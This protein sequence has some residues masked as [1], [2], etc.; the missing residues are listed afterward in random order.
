MLDKNK[1][2]KDVYAVIDKLQ[3]VYTSMDSLLSGVNEILE[4]NQR[5]EKEKES[6]SCESEIL[7]DLLGMVECLMHVTQTYGNMMSRAVDVINNHNPTKA[8]KEVRAVI[9]DLAQALVNRDGGSDPDGE[10]N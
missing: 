4:I 3:D 9:D 10:L 6:C 2:Q 1:L 8:P 7:D 5:H